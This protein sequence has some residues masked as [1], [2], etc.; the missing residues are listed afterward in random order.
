MNPE[1]RNIKYS[2]IGA[3]SSRKIEVTKPANENHKNNLVPFEVV[4]LVVLKIEIKAT[5][6][7]RMVTI[8]FFKKP[9][10]ILNNVGTARQCIMQR[11]ALIAPN[12]SAQYILFVCIIYL[13]C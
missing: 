3:L 10:P 13:I 8:G 6:T 9:I 7:K 11:N 12:L 5:M 2:K 1:K 4:L